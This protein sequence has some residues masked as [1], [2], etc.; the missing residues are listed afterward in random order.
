MNR[1]EAIRRS[2]G[3]LV[4]LATTVPVMPVAAGLTL[5]YFGFAAGIG[6]NRGV[7]VLFDD[8]VLIVQDDV[9]TRRLTIPRA[10]LQSRERWHF[11][12]EPSEPPATDVSARPSSDVTYGRIPDHPTALCRATGGVYVAATQHDDE[13]ATFPVEGGDGGSISMLSVQIG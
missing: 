12:I 3:A 1:L 5:P 7:G 6:S 11:A 2:G 4:S 8:P 10:Q 9:T 13:T